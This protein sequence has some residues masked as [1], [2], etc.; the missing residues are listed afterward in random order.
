MAGGSNGYRA[1]LVRRQPTP[2]LIS[3]LPGTA[4]L[5]PVISFSTSYRELDSAVRRTMRRI[6]NGSS[7]DN[8]RPL[9]CTGGSVIT[10]RG[11][12][13]GGLLP[14]C[15]QDRTN[16][17]H[18][19]PCREH[20]VWWFPVGLGWLRLDFL[21]FVNRRSRRSG[22]LKLEGSQRIQIGEPTGA[23]TQDPRLKKAKRWI[24]TAAWFCEGFPVDLVQSMQSFVSTDSMEL[25]EFFPLRRFLAHN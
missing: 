22:N 9:D 4:G 6:G 10:L 18:Q 14:R 12:R 8:T 24:H 15:Y 2:G 25:Q 7:S 19:A 13:A 17:S 16:Q 23:R 11:R 1:A 5:P 21:K 3:S 20:P